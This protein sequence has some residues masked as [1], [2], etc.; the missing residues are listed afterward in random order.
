M[1]LIIV[2]GYCLKC[3]L[4][5]LFV[6]SSDVTT[7]KGFIV[8]LLGHSAHIS[9]PIVSAYICVCSY[10]MCEG[11]DP[12]YRCRCRGR[13]TNVESVFFSPTFSEFQDQ[14][15]WGH[16][17][18]Q[19]VFPPCCNFLEY[20]SDLKTLVFCK[21]VSSCNLSVM[22]SMPLSLALLKV[23]GRLGYIVFYA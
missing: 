20:P 21:S 14:T 12:C 1:S 9:L 18:T 23:S 8:F 5:A 22:N 19:A 6:T 17:L 2:W 10:G 7:K 13:G 3:S 4:I 16:P 15:H 11:A